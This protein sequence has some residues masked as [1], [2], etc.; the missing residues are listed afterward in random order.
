MFRSEDNGTVQA[1]AGAGLGS[2]LVPLLA[3]DTS[4]PLIAVL[5][6][7]LEPRRIALMWHR[8]RYRSPASREFVEI[9]QAVCAELADGLQR[10]RAARARRHDRA[11]TRRDPR[12]T[13]DAAFAGGGRRARWYTP[14]VPD[15]PSQQVGPCLRTRP[16]AP[17]SSP[18]SV[19]PAPSAGR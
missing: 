18:S 10:R 4:D 8:D 19:P 7:V 12:L 15:N 6:T 2:A 3:V 17:S 13:V 1:M 5:P 9:A 11:D 16:E 14:A